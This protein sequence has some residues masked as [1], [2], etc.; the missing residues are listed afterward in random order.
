MKKMSFWFSGISLSI[1]IITY[2]SF[3]TRLGN[4]DI[5]TE[6]LLISV[7]SILV[8]ILICFQVYN[9]IQLKSEFKDFEEK[10][11]ANELENNQ[12]IKEK[13]DIYKVNLQKE[14]QEKFSLLAF[15]F[16]VELCF[17]K[18]V[19]S[20]FLLRNYLFLLYFGNNLQGSEVNKIK[21]N[22][23]KELFRFIAENMEKIKK[24]SDVEKKGLLNIIKLNENI[25]GFSELKEILKQSP[26]NA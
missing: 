18:E 2:L 25:I 7:L 16:Y 5:S 3:H 1:S 22:I 4:L 14:I 10:M 11:K 23:T 26:K 19:N 24:Y 15:N 6:S 21:S 12:K 17:D 20:Y 13:N 8:T 9:S